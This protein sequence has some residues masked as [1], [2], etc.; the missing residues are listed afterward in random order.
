MSSFAPVKPL[1]AAVAELGDAQTSASPEALVALLELQ[2]MLLRELLSDCAACA[3]HAGRKTLEEADVRLAVE[4]WRMSQETLPSV[5]S[6]L[7]EATKLNATP[8]P[9]M[10]KR[11]GDEYNV[12]FLPAPTDGV[13]YDLAGVGKDGGARVKKRPLPTSPV[14]STSA[15]I[16]STKRR[17]KQR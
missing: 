10:P 8:L 6:M 16:A 14:P 5:G 17:R 15:K 7:T 4:L 11:D 9:E 13:E 12:L 3:A 2:H 1:A